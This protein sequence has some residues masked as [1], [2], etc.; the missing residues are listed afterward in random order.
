MPSE[1]VVEQQMAIPAPMVADSGPGVEAQ[2]PVS[3][4]FSH[5]I[6]LQYMY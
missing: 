3:A 2:Q 5:P 6:T 1:Q 4:D